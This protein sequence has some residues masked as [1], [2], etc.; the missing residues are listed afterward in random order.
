[1]KKFALPLVIGVLAL[2]VIGA[3]KADPVVG[4]KTTDVVQPWT[5][6]AGVEWS[7]DSHSPTLGI[8]GVDYGFE[9]TAASNNPVIPSIYVDDTFKTSGSSANI[10]DAGIA[11]RQDFRQNGGSTTPYVGAGVGAYYASGG[12]SNH[13]N[14]GGKVFGGVEFSGSWL[15][16]A[17]YTPRADW[18]GA[19]LSTYGIEVGLRF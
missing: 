10:A 17:N 9:K 12:G 5:I 6:K 3:A 8:V 2:S 13:T 4:S 1:M 15:V 18:N 14:I 16:E 11:I 19:H 7:T